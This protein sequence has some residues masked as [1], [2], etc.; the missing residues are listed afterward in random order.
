M[1][2]RDRHPG[3]LPAEGGLKYLAPLGRSYRYTVRRTDGVQV[4][5][6]GNVVKHLG[7]FKKLL[8]EE[9]QRRGIA[10]HTEEVC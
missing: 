7:K 4:E 8:R 3:A 6:D 9:A 1:R 2:G 10:W 5:V